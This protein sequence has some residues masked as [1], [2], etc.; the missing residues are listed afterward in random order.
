MLGLVCVVLDRVQ[1]NPRALQATTVR[2]VQ[3]ILMG[4][5]WLE[6]TTCPFFVSRIKDRL[7]LV[8][9]SF[10]TV[11]EFRVVWSKV[12]KLSPPYSLTATKYY[13]DTWWQEASVPCLNSGSFGQGC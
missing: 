6:H 9:G 1:D 4:V 8:A 10:C 3:R 11:F 12:L 13:R 7:Y 2:S 5:S